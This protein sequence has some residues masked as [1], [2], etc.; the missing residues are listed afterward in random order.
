MLAIVEYIKKNG[1][2][3]A[4]QTLKLKAK[5]YEHKIHLKYDQIESDMSQKEVQECRGLILDKK[6]L[7][8]ISM[9]FFK[10]F[11]N[12]ETNAAK[13]DWK[14]AHV[15]EKVDGSMMQVYWDPYAEKWFAGT[16]GT[17]EGEG[18]VNNKS[19][20]TFNDLFW[21]VVNDK[22]PNML[23]WLNKLK[24]CT[25]VFELTTPYNIVVKPHGESSITLLAARDNQTLKELRYVDLKVL[26]TTFGVP[27]V[28][29]FNLNAKNFG[30]LIRTFE[31]MPWSEEG[32][33]V[34]D[35]NFNRVKIKNP[36]YCAVHHLKGKTAE[37]NILTIVKS[38]E[39]EEFAATFIER[40]TEV[41]LLKDKYDKLV[42]KLET[43]QVELLPFLPKDTSKNESKKYALK[44]FDIVKK[45]DIPQF[46]GLYFS[47]K[48]G[49]TSTIKNYIN[50]Y[51]N[52]IL[53]RFLLGK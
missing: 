3:K 27:I 45:Y 14:T 13:I 26:A 21:Q 51:D 39:I 2:D 44:V 52:K 7:D 30:D 32:Y 34:M 9:S 24:H 4:I 29:L 8:V 5:I 22:A 17:A 23:R 36:A 12:G 11:N 1:L 38:N 15:F 42:N 35:E 31:G 18:E 25:F 37:H 6:T 48:D 53:Y 19:G 43:I 47:L 41:Y 46:S 40:K 49:K 10:F 16:T 50:D 20:T 33:V 28:K